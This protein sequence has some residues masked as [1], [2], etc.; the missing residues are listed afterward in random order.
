MKKLFEKLKSIDK[1]TIIRTILQILAYA[2]Q[3]VAVSG[4]NTFASSPVYQWIS[5]IVTVVIT[6]IAYWFNNDWSKFA[7]M[8]RDIF[9]MLK[10]GKI[11]KEELSAF[12]EK[13]HNKEGNDK[14]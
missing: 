3:L 10:D 8:A 11:T 13:H 2:N 7:I 5:L 14:K 1:G 9:D 4:R 12:I 6:A